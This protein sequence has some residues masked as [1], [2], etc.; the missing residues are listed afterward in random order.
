[1]T[2][3]A[4]VKKHELID[5]TVRPYF[6]YYMEHLCGKTILLSDLKRNNDKIKDRCVFFSKE[7]EYYFHKEWL[8]NISDIK[9]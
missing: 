3:K 2:F 1:M 5:R 9:E 8:E 6:F 7:N 4:T